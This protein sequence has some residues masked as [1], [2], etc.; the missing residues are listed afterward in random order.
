MRGHTLQMLSHLIQRF[1]LAYKSHDLRV[2]RGR[3]V[4]TFIAQLLEQLLARTQ[5]DK[6]NLN[7]LVGFE[8][9]E[10]DQLSGEVDDFDR[11]SHIQN[12]DLTTRTLC[13]A[14]Q[15]Q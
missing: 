2:V 10:F 13:A 14:L 15:D 9:A 4:L 12:K 3:D 1:R 5:P 7:V 8:P 6:F 11:L